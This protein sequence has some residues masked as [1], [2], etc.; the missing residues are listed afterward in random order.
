[1]NKHAICNVEELPEGTH[2]VKQITER[3]SVGVY[4]IDGSL[5]AFRNHCPHAG[6]PVCEGTVSGAILCDENFERH[7]A[8]DGKI[9]KCPWHAWEFLLPEGVTLTKPVYRLIKHPVVI[10]EG[11]IFVELAGGAAQPK[12]DAAP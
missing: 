4:N 5:V 2:L 7:L 8:H 1:M 12:K 3:M 11:Q 6:A 9:L 10:E